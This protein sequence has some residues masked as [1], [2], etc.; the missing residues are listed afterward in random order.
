MREMSMVEQV[1][2]DTLFLHTVCWKVGQRYNV[3]VTIYKYKT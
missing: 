2:K 1:I 3:T